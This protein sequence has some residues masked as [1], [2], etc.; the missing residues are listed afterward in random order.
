MISS[1]L[2]A[3]VL[4]CL[5]QP[6]AAAAPSKS[7]EPSGTRISQRVGPFVN[8]LHAKARVAIREKRYKV[9]SEIYKTILTQLPERVEIP[10]SQLE[11]T[12]LLLALHNQRQ[13]SIEDARKTFA[14]G[15]QKMRKTG[16]PKLLTALAL[17]ESKNGRMKKAKYLV[18]YL[19][20]QFP[21]KGESLAKW[22]MFNEIP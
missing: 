9:A 21:E 16:S 7:L 11:D 10:A 20:D 15:L 5:F 8:S 1:T 2:S 13:K 18:Q 22:K 3:L 14:Q 17:M 6:S 4:L 12:Y 19:R